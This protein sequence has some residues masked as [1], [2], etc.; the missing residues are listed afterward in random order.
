MLKLIL[1]IQRCM[2]HNRGCN[3][4]DSTYFC[5]QCDNEWDDFLK[6]NKKS[7]INK[8]IKKKQYKYIRMDRNG[9]E[10][11]LAKLNSRI[12]IWKA[13]PHKLRH[14]MLLQ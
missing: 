10:I 5:H 14:L 12:I 9:K 7:N 13:I 4:F 8:K 11:T 6:V 1:V 2:L 3:L